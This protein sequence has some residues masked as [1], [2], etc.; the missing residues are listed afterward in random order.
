ML[1]HTQTSLFVYLAIGR[2]LK[3][4]HARVITYTFGMERTHLSHV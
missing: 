4:D 3:L 2:L 1:V